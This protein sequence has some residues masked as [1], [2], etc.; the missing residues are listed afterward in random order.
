MREFVFIAFEI[1]FGYMIVK[2]NASID[3]FIFILGML[4]AG[5]LAGLESK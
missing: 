4:S 5:Y 3:M 1:L 2:L